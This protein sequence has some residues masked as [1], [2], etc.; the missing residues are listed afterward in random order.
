MNLLW[1]ASDSADLWHRCVCI[2]VSAQVCLSAASYQTF[3]YFTQQPS[4]TERKH[5]VDP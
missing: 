4:T 3:R 5:T 1:F 2:G